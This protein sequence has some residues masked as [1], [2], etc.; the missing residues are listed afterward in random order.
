MIVALLSDIH[1]NLH[2]LE[3]VLEGIGQYSPEAVLCAGDIVGYG[4]YP[5]ECCAL[6]RGAGIA[7]VAG[8]HDIAALGS[9][10]RGM[11]PY[12]AAAAL[13]TADRLN[14]PS[15]DLL[16]S[17]PGSVRRQAG[18]HEVAVFHGSDSSPDEY[19][20]EDDV[21]TGIL[22]RTSSQVAVLGHTHIPFVRRLAEGLVVNPGSV[23][24]PRDGDPRGSF[25]ILDTEG[26]TCDVFRVAY[27][28]E[29]A[30]E[31]VLEAG[32]PMI[33]AQRLSVGR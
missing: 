24:Q 21:D 10:T 25:A 16:S 9:Q 17:L 28:V 1:S 11:N 4:A 27:D 30:A 7:S 13:W 12:A 15:K 23:G 29:A 18:G 8:N 3:A 6:V 5:N 26:M 19:V 14:R 22:A 33:L 31:A 2:A 20:H 32:L